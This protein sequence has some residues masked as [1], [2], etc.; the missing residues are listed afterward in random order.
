MVNKIMAPTVMAT[1][2]IAVYPAT[3]KKCVQSIA[4]GGRGSEMIPHFLEN[5]QAVQ[6]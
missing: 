3:L 2:I 6:T 4:V 1:A 5:K